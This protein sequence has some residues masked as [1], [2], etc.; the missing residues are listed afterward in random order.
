M[1]DEYDFSD[2]VR[3]KY[4]QDPDSIP[5]HSQ[6]DIS[7]EQVEEKDVAWCVVCGWG[8]CEKLGGKVPCPGPN[9]GLRAAVEHLAKPKPAVEQAEPVN[10]QFSVAGSEDWRYCNHF[11][12]ER[13]KYDPGYEVREL[14]THPPATDERLREAHRS[15]FHAAIK[16]FAEDPVSGAIETG[17]E[18]AAWVV[19]EALLG[20]QEPNK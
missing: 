15:G 17:E 14:Y 10:R 5:E 11:Q 16:M 9:L 20:T 18:E 1:K 3:G 19:R 4:E 7:D 6:V 8:D 2:G 12:W 13:Y